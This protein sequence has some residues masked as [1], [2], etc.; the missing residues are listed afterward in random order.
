MIFSGQ[1]VIR[2]K[3]AVTMIMKLHLLH[4]AEFAIN[5]RSVDTRQHS[6]EPRLD[7]EAL[8]PEQ[9]QLKVVEGQGPKARVLMA[10]VTA[11]ANGDTEPKTAGLM[12]RIRI[13]GLLGM[14]LEALEEPRC[15]KSK[16]MRH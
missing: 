7:L 4:S 3:M 14:Q 8:N 10:T 12:K 6:A 9:E 13:R 2:P 5:A 1:P 16:R 11:V 15:N